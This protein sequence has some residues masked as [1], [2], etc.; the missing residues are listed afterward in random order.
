MI[1]SLH[2]LG[3]GAE[4]GVS[5]IKKMDFQTQ[6]PPPLQCFT[7]INAPAVMTGQCNFLRTGSRLPGVYLCKRVS[8]FLFGFFFLL[9]KFIFEPQ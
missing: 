9:I 7:Q 4:H 1:P 2:Y 3:G 6:V 8:Y 5:P